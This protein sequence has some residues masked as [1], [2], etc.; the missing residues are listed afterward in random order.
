MARQATPDSKWQKL[1]KEFAKNPRDVQTVPKISRPGRW[2]YACALNGSLYIRHAQEPEHEERACR[3]VR[4]R[5]LERDEFERM[6]ELYNRWSKGEKIWGHCRSEDGQPDS[7]FQ[8]YWFGIFAAVWP[9]KHNFGGFKKQESLERW[10]RIIQEY[11]ENP[12]DVRTMPINRRA[13]KWFYVYVDKN[14]L[15][16]EKSRAKLDGESCQISQRRFLRPSELEDMWLYYL[17]RRDGENIFREATQR[18]RNQ[19]YWYGIFADLGW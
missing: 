8:M 17:R 9:P 14:S 12:R 19:V 2:F 13:G 18:C 1:I 15:Y 3:L 4:Q 16:V 5:H 7:K 11:T 10:Q 6:L